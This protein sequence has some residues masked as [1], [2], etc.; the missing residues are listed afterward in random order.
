MTS[1]RE[2]RKV[3]LT[4]NG[5]AAL[6]QIKEY[7][8]DILREVFAPYIFSDKEIEDFLSFADEE[9]LEFSFPTSR[10]ETGFAHM[11]DA[12]VVRQY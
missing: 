2:I 12:G 7:A 10:D 4:Q 9:Y 1:Q 8:K 3:E 11:E 5:S 6:Y